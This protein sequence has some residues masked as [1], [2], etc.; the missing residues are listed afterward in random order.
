MKK[1][2]E[3]QTRVEVT[4]VSSLT[5]KVIAITGTPGCGKTTLANTLQ[6]KSPGD[7][8]EVVNIAELIKSR[9]LYSE[10]DDEMNCS[11]FDAKRVRKEIEKIVSDA[12]QAGK[13]AVI[14][15]FHSLDFLRKKSLDKVFVLRTDT[16]KLWERLELRNYSER[17]IKENVEAEIFMECLN[18]CQDKFGPDSVVCLYSNTE[19]DVNR[20]IATIIGFIE[21]DN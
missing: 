21:E 11:I 20:N 15:E 3:K 17:K 7:I 2:I 1:V 12:K 18:D 8:F 5:T 16:E 13:S 9:K 4:T 19:D 14:L 6:S 10:W